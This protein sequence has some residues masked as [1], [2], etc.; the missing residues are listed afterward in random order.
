M[1]DFWLLLVAAP[2]PMRAVIGL[3]LGVTAVSLMVAGHM[4]QEAWMNDWHTSQRR[5]W[6]RR[7]QRNFSRS[8]QSCDAADGSLPNNEESRSPRLPK[9]GAGVVSGSRSTYRVWRD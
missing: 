9:L 5:R 3:V 6:L 1:S 8:S 7:V 2:W 4:A